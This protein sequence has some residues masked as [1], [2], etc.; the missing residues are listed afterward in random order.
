[1]Q[2]LASIIHTFLL[3]SL[4]SSISAHLFAS[5]A[6][7]NVNGN[8]KECY[9]WFETNNSDYFERYLKESHLW[10]NVGSPI[11]TARIHNIESFTR[12]LTMAGYHVTS[13]FKT[14]DIL[15]GKAFHDAY[16]WAEIAKVARNLS[17]ITNGRPVILENEGATKLLLKQGVISVDYE[18]LLRVISAQTWPEIWF[19]HAPAGRK[20][21]MRSLSSDIAMA[22]SKGI[23]N[24]RLIEASS[25]GLTGSQKNRISQS[26]F[27][28]TLA[29]DSN[30]ISIIYLDDETKNFWKLADTGFAVS[31]A[32]GNTVII[33][34]G[35][36]DIEKGEKVKSALAKNQCMAN[37][38][39]E[40]SL[41]KTKNS[42][43]L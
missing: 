34:P 33:Y 37:T 28:K 32:A 43:G 19:W 9:V 22:I 39:A 24:S 10:K 21:P 12:K 42:S 15:R 41:L 5:T 35:V 6:G 16:A 8:Y 23:P 18:S 30:P 14:S 25:A 26:N 2:V 3:V 1:M 27:R 36:G 38:P 40:V 29:L 13:G 31:A 7:K 11:V 17:H 4:L 20:E